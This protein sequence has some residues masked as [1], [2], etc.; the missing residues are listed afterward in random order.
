MS[1][2]DLTRENLVV[3]ERAADDSKAQALSLYLL[4]YYV[5]SSVVGIAGGL[6]WSPYGWPG[7]MLAIIALL[8]LALVA[9]AAL[10]ALPMR[11]PARK[12]ES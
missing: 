8:I 3:R 7:V 2:Y 11:Y 1:I 12:D 6:L 5:G 10:R 9:T 4:F